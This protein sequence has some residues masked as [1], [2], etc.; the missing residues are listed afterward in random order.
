MI[1]PGSSASP[2]YVSS[3]MVAVEPQSY[4][5]GSLSESCP[6]HLRAPRGSVLSV[7]VG[8]RT[9]DVRHLDPDVE[10]VSSAQEQV[11]LAGRVRVCRAV[12]VQ[13]W[14]CFRHVSDR[15]RRDEQPERR[16]C[17]TARTMITGL[18]LLA[19]LVFGAAHLRSS[20]SVGSHFWNIAPPASQSPFSCR[21]RPLQCQDT[22]PKASPTRSA[23]PPCKSA[24]R[25]G[26]AMLNRADRHLVL[27]QRRYRA[28]DREARERL[29]AGAEGCRACT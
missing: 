16:T 29:A 21:A 26:N 11:E 19:V 20:Q 3:V 10:A 28:V 4:V 12:Q 1:R 8:P 27:R 24:T 18:A 23:R 17:S 2:K 5:P 14:R 15:A 6:E 13:R 7:V 22:R 25:A 9:K